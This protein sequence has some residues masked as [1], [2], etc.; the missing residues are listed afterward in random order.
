MCSL[1]IFIFL[2]VQKLDLQNKRALFMCIIRRLS[3][4]HE[5]VWKSRD[6]SPLILNFGTVWM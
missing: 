1:K 2:A 5:D 3:A 4:R 6:I